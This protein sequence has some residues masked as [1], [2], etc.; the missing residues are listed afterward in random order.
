MPGKVARGSRGRVSERLAHSTGSPLGGWWRGWG[1]QTWLLLDHLSP[2]T[3]DLSRD[4]G[5]CVEGRVNGA[6]RGVGEPSS[7]MPD[8]PYNNPDGG[9]HRYTKSAMRKRRL[10]EVDRWAGV[11]RPP[12]GRRRGPEAP[13]RALGEQEGG[14]GGPHPSSKLAERRDT[15]IP[16]LRQAVASQANNRLAA[17]RGEEVTGRAPTPGQSTRE[18]GLPSASCPPAPPRPRWPEARRGP[19]P[20]PLPAQTG[21]SLEPGGLLLLQNNNICSTSALQ[22][23]GFLSSR[24]S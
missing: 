20:D 8:Y 19:K 18:P 17:L 4:S 13:G 1:T 16:E 21:S 11:S 15:R 3:S 23:T 2:G 6:G 14:A 9:W 5:G 7:S 12:G 22:F 10:G 24:P